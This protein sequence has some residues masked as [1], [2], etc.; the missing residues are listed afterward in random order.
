MISAK[1]PH[2]LAVYAEDDLESLVNASCMLQQMDLWLNAQGLGSCWLGMPNPTPETAKADGLPFVIVLAFGRPAEEP[3]RKDIAE[4][5]RKPLSEI[6][7]LSGMEQLLEPVRLAPSAVNRQPWHLSGSVNSMR[8]CGK[9]NNM[10]QKAMFGDMPY[11]DMGIALCH[12]WL[13]AE[14]ENQFLSFEREN[15]P[16]DIPNGYEY[17]WTVHL[18]S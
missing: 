15:N 16:K 11:M 4:F 17:V 13:S 6:T 10:L 7:G 5:K 3:H 8:L 2:Y 9:K 12:L 1:T 14:K 18:K